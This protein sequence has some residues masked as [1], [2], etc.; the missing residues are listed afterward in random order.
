MDNRAGWI[1]MEMPTLVLFMAL[2]FT[3]KNSITTVM[4][5]LMAAWLIHYG[6]RIFIFPLRTRTKGKKIPIAIVSMAMFFNLVNGFL[7]GYYLGYLTDDYEITW[8]KDPRF[9]IGVIVFISGFIINQLADHHLIHLRKPGQ[10]G[11]SIPTHRLFR[12]VSCRNFGGEILEWCGFAL[13]A[14]NLPALSF[15]VWTAANLVPRAIQ[16]HRWYRAT[17]PDYPAGRKALIPGIL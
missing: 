1:V 2:F 6:N 12:Y 14:W 17:F 4:L 5:F 11:Y 7:N 16:H 3:G 13:M 8:I 15:A 10:K 9:I